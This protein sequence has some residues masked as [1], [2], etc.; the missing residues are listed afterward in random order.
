MGV[1]V[2]WKEER[3]V[4]GYHPTVL[5]NGGGLVAH[6][7]CGRFHMTLGMSEYRRDLGLVSSTLQRLINGVSPMGAHNI[8]STSEKSTNEPIKQ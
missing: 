4:C 3:L 8:A 6:H 7:K 1:F 5:S 2:R